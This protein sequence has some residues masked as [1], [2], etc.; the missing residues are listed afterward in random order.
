MLGH[1]WYWGLTKRYVAYFGTIFNDI[2]IDRTADGGDNATNYIKVPLSYAPKKNYILRLAQEPSIQGDGLA[3]ITLP[4]MSFEITAITPDNERNLSL[5]Q[6][7][8]FKHQDDANKLS[9][10]HVGKPFNITFNLYIYTKYTEDMMKII[11]QIHPFFA[12]EW[13]ASVQL[14]PEAGITSMDIPI[15]LV[16]GPV[17]EDEFTG[18]LKERKYLIYTYT[19]NMRAWYYGPK[20]NKPIIKFVFENLY[21]ATTSNNE[22]I[23]TEGDKVGYIKI[24]PGLDANGDP[25]SNSSVSIPPGE[26]WVDDDFGFC[27]DKFGS[28]E[29]DGE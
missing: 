28:L 22:I 1:N 2:H 16:G 6:R 15:E 27:I 3:A 5:L 26:I 14:I 12:P 7:H 8:S 18:S 24:T 13:T 25:T 23:A 9:Y 19:F 21:M 11:E 10:V 17:I 29:L 4:R 20:Y